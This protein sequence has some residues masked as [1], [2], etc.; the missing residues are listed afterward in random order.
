MGRDMARKI[1]EVYG[2]ADLRTIAD[3]AGII[4]KSIVQAT[5]RIA[6]ISIPRT[7]CGW[8]GEERE[9]EER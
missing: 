2:T 6:S 4:L 7:N 1:I 5:V 8:I 9:N 3:S